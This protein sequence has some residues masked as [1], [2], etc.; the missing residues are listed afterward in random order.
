LTPARRR[1][2][3]GRGRHR[4]LPDAAL[5]AVEDVV[6]GVDARR[7]VRGSVRF[8]REISVAC[9]VGV[10]GLVDLRLLDAIHRLDV[11]IVH[12]GSWVRP[13]CVL[14]GP[15]MSA[16]GGDRAVRWFDVTY[17]SISTAPGL[18]PL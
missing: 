1:G 13:A 9:G 3:S 11:D 17:V 15:D 2:E 5:P 8:G 12:I 18:R 14:V 7:E 4:R 6:R 10:S 16:L